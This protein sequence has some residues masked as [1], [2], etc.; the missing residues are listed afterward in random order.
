[1]VCSRQ[2]KWTRRQLRNKYRENKADN[3]G[4]RWMPHASSQKVLRHLSTLFH[5][6]AAGQLSDA[7]LLE[8]I[9]TGGAEEAEAAFAALVE[10]HGAMVLGVCRRVL[11]NRDGADDAFQATFLVLAK[12]A[13]AIA[14]REQLASWLHGVARRAAL[15]ARARAARR[16]A[17]ETRL[18][19]MLPAEPRDL[20]MASE[21][22]AILDEELGRLPERH[23]AA[24]VLCELE[25]LTRRD[26][27]I[28]LGISEGTLSSRLAR[29]KMRLRNRLSQRGFALSATALAALLTQDA[30]AVVVS[31]ALVESTIRVATLVATGSSLA[32]VVP[33]SVATL[34]RGVLKA[35]LLAKLK[36]AVIG[37]A[38]LALVSTGVLAQSI[39]SP[40][41]A[42]DDRLKAVERKLDRLLEVLGGSGRRMP[43]LNP[44]PATTPTASGAAP[45]AEPMTPT[46][47]MPPSPPQLAAGPPG[48]DMRPVAAPP[49]YLRARRAN[50]QDLSGFLDSV[51]Q[52]LNDLERRL[53]DLERRIS[54]SHSLV[55]PAAPG[56]GSPSAPA[57]PNAPLPPGVPSTLP[58]PTTSDPH[59]NLPASSPPSADAAPATPRAGDLPPLPSAE[60]RA[61]DLPLLPSAENRAS[62]DI[63]PP[64]E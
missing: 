25:G 31:T 45:R 9:V 5:C 13:A 54:S 37:L 8:R 33:T 2:K 10:R 22:R 48:T 60:N 30:H 4:E 32:G 14:R 36:F 52:R 59:L 29:A 3:R 44:S 20:A 12:K 58:R 50:R 61:S 6:G 55:P 18:A 34:T 63:T 24:L 43:A 19:A 11:G 15:D 16:K 35:M 57:N 23:R 51:E 47:L 39:G 41:P 26:A 27:A 56:P 38:G 64:S 62:S 17:R 46:A 49:A 21:L 42:D 28:R 53:N 1:M 40:R 7:E